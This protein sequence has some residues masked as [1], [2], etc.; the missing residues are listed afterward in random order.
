VDAISHIN[1]ASRAIAAAANVTPE[2]VHNL[3]AA[4]SAAKVL[5]VISPGISADGDP[6]PTFRTI[7]ESGVIVVTCFVGQHE[8][9]CTRILYED[10]DSSWSDGEKLLWDISSRLGDVPCE[11]ARAVGPASTS[12]ALFTRTSARAA[13]EHYFQLCSLTNV[14]QNGSR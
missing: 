6:R 8:L 13:V 14:S 12:V 11:L 7:R 3:Q 9:N 5:V 1:R 10:R 2:I 4:I